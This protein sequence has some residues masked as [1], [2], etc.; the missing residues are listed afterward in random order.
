MRHRFKSRYS[1]QGKMALT[2]AA[3]RP[4]ELPQIPVYTVWLRTATYGYVRRS[5]APHHDAVDRV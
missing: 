4:R 5:T 1:P 3:A 2:R